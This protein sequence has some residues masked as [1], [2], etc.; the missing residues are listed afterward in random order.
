[1]VYSHYSQGDTVLKQGQTAL[2]GLSTP[3]PLHPKPHT[4]QDPWRSADWMQELQELGE[5]RTLNTAPGTKIE[6]AGRGQLF[7]V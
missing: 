3:G 5:G 4:Q 6:A 1:M 7:L 2:V